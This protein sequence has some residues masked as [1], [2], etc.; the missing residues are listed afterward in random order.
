MNLICQCS[1][2]CVICFMTDKVIVFVKLFLSPI[3]S[4]VIFKKKNYLQDCFCG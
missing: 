1:L 4:F 2:I 3:Q